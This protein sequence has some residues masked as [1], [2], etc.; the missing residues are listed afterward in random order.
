M[1]RNRILFFLSFLI[2]LPAAARGQ[3]FLEEEYHKNIKVFQPKPILKKE[4]VDI[5]P[6][7][8]LHLN[9]V[10]TK[11]YGAG[12][13]LGYHIN[14]YIWAG[15]QFANFWSALSQQDG[16]INEFTTAPRRRLGYLGTV[17]VAWTPLFSKGA[18]IGTFLSYW[19]L[20]LF[21]GGGVVSS[22]V[23]DR[24]SNEYELSGAGEFGIATR[25][26]FTKW[27]A[28]VVELSDMLYLESYAD[29]TLFK[30]NL[31]LRAG[32]SFFVPPDFKYRDAK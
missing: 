24:S 28:L 26:Y 16:E 12:V 23:S 19:D 22:W 14:E 32:L 5:T 17:R 13:M 15:A 30:N 18:L 2:L 25:F 11:H 6:F 9:P 29:D 4:R 7:G 1:M 27:L 3:G 10:E 31:M 20:Y 8:I 21:G